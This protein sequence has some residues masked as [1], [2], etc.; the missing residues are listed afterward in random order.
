MKLYQ[1]KVTLTDVH[2]PVWKRA[3]LSP[4]ITL[5]KLHLILQIVMGWEDR[6]M[7]RFL[8]G[9]REYSDPRFES[10]G[11]ALDER[12]TVLGVIM[13]APGDRL[14]Y[15]YDFGDDWRHELIYEEWIQSDEHVPYAICIEGA[16]ACPPED[17]GGPY[18]YNDLVR[19]LKNPTQKRYKQM[20]DWAGDR[21]D[22]EA[23]NLDAINKRL[24]N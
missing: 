8:H 18:A 17:C 4:E 21:F 22:P 15:E 12:K 2:A 11:N 24:S 19:A 13:K 5:G 7:H 23:F 14:V 6:H 10:E 20:L 16:R 3:L 1:I 9:G